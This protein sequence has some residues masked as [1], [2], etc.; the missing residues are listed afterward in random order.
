MR[1]RR[2]TLVVDYHNLTP[3]RLLNGWEPVA[4]HGVAWG[5]AQLGAL[6][7]RTAL[8]IADSHYNELDLIAAG[9]RADD[10]RPDPRS[11]GRARGRAR[12]RGARTAARDATPGSTD[13][14]FVGRLAA[15][16]AQHDVV[17]AF[18][19]YRRFHDP[20]SRLF[21][22]GG[23]ADDAYGTTLRRFAD[24][25]GLDDAVT[26][27]GPVSSTALAAHYV[28]AD[29]FVVCSEHEG[30]CVPLLE[31]MHHD[32]PI[33][34]YATGRRA[35]D[36][37]RRGP[38]APDQGSVHGRGRG[39]PRR[40]RRPLRTATRDRR[41]RAPRRLRTVADRP[42]ARRRARAE[43]VRV[44]IVAERVTPAASTARGW[45]SRLDRHFPVV[46]GVVAF[47][48]YWAT[49]ATTPTEWDSVQL[50]SASTASTSARTRLTPPATGRTSGSAALIRAMTPLGHCHRAH[51]RDRCSRERRT[52]A[53]VAWL[54][55]EL[56]GR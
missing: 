20:D 25:L 46:A 2:E 16:K 29:V 43:R 12:R 21:L 41:A 4:A 38:A 31:A 7:A 24:K 13:W 52:V 47:V 1:E 53:L 10:G 5:R 44:T 23:G 14:L 51:A 26:I 48:V 50:R 11:A 6:A 55:R 18:C 17:K 40:A 27:T 37:R 56:G 15:N 36:A 35:R 28:N 8:G 22:V 34:A 33:V 19:A 42:R 3:L 30:F 32:V 49:R 45:T 9:Y 39:R 54:G